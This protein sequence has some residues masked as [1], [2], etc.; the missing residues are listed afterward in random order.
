MPHHYKVTVNLDVDAEVWVEA[1]DEDAA[2]TAAEAMTLQQMKDASTP[3]KF[4]TVLNT[5]TATTSEH[6]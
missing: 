5:V 1:D 2:K 4:P 6:Q 3:R